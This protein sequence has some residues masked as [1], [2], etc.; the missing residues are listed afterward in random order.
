MIVLIRIG[1]KVVT[2]SPG[3]VGQLP[4]G[5]A[6]GILPGGLE[7]IHGRPLEDPD[8]VRGTLVHHGL[9]EEQA[10][11]ALRGLGFKAEPGQYDVPE[12]ENQKRD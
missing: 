5:L 4:N 10:A 8:V 2:L 6:I 11:T 3:E 1:D 9:T 7:A 12:V